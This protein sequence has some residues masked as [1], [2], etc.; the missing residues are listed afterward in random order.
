LQQR[1]LFVYKLSDVLNF[2]CETEK[3]FEF[4]KSMGYTDPC[5]LPDGRFAA[6]LP[7]M[8]TAAIITCSRE[9]LRTGIDERWCF[10]DKNKALE[11]LRKW[12]GTG[13]P[14]GWHR[15]IPSNRRRT[16]GDPLREYIEA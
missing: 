8:F 1:S 15:H 16:D 9:H 5:V 3:I 13:D 10:H 11:S 14:E 7:L 4:L 6:V 2:M 12:N